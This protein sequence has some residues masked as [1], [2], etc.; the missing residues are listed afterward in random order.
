VAGE[1]SID[2]PALPADDRLD[3]QPLTAR[4]V[5]L[6]LLLGSHPPDLPVRSLVQTATLF[7]ISE[8]TTRVALSRLAAD[9]DVIGADG[10]YRLSSRLVA[11]QRSQDEARQPAIRQWNGT[12]EIAVLHPDRRGTPEQA[13]LAAELTALRLGELRHGVWTRPA[14]LQRQWP[15]ALL[16]RVWRFD[17]RPTADRPKY[18]RSPVAMAATLWNLDGWSER[19]GSLLEALDAAIDPGR[20]FV[21]AAAVVRH[22]QR[23]PLLPASLL[24][25]D[26]PGEQLRSAYAGYVADLG[27]FLRVERARHEAR[28]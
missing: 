19:A 25:S 10:R 13:A 11:R 15:L 20:R 3:L 21:I 9:G 26:W 24:P 12:W 2:A 7:G 23:D 6:S 27:R 16:D 17:G 4:S 5:I 18:G 1:A 22:L 28:P 14:N 8:G